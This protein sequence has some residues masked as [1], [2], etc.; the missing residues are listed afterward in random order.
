MIHF[1]A[2]AGEK[3]MRAYLDVRGNAIADRFEI[4]A[5]EKLP[6]KFRGGTYVFSALEQLSAPMER[7]VAELHAQ[8]SRWEG[9]RILNR[10]GRALRRYELLRELARRGLNDHRAA[11]ATEDLSGLRYPVFVRG[12]RTHEGA[13]S[14]LL[15]NRSDV[16]AWIGRLRVLGRKLD[17][18]L[19]VEFNDTADVRGVYRKYAAFVIGDRIL[20]RSLD[21]GTN[22][23]LK[24]D[25]TMYTTETLAE[26]YEYVRTNPHERE[27]REIF[28]LAGVDYGRIDYAIKNGRVQTWEINLHPTLGRGREGSKHPAP[29]SVAAMHAVTKQYV[30]EQLRDAWVAI[31][32]DDDR[33]LDVALDPAL[34]REALA[35]R[36]P[37][38]RSPM[39]NAVR[40]ALRPIK[41]LLLRHGT[42]IFGAVGNWMR[43]TRA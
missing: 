4:V 24:R 26:E 40:R 35:T 12:E 27:L 28:A 14:P 20:P 7:L 8:L 5:Y 37:G 30:H 42:R 21:Y 23:M 18:L 29:E 32:L 39:M 33:E 11:L 6:S 43:R 15:H 25:G 9:V 38:Q 22:W 10:P 17:E 13:L 19:V 3:L 2:P 1:L 16:E 34:I 41:P 36:Q 31:D